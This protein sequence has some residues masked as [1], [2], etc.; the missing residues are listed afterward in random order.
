MN[1]LIEYLFIFE[2]CS[3]AG[4]ILELF[5]RSISAKKIKNPGFLSGCCLPIYG[6]GGLALYLIC[7]TAN[8]IVKTIH[9][10]LL[11]IFII[12][13]IVM[14]LIELIGGLISLNRFHLRLWDYSNE[15]FNYKGVVC[16]KFSLYWG[17]ICLFFYG[18]IFP[19]L[20]NFAKNIFNGYFYILFIGFYFGVF[21]MD[22]SS[23]LN[24]AK[25]IRSYTKEIKEII[26]F[27][28]LKNSAMEYVDKHTDKNPKR[29][30]FLQNS[31]IHSYIIVKRDVAKKRKEHFKE[32]AD[33]FREELKEKAE[34]IK[35][36]TENIIDTVEEKILKKKADK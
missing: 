13:C 35:M 21:S 34:D 24:L 17:I 6:I 9:L 14:T 29:I 28:K 23:S 12:G 30:Y 36:A 32:F 11:L 2:F 15:K 10:K 26:N 3:T 8:T 7:S 33:D 16:L 19:N 5:Y 25:S 31:T 27:E 20:N 18:L 22:L 1:F 4:W